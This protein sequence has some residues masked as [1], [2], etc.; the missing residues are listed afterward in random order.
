M[1]D[2]KL[3]EGPSEEAAELGLEPVGGNSIRKDPEARGGLMRARTSR[4]PVWLKWSGQKGG[5]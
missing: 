5:S 1:K 4:G 3:R 2:V